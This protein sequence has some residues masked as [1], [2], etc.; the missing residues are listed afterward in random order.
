MRSIGCSTARL[1]AAIGLAALAVAAPAAWVG[2]QQPP[3]PTSGPDANPLDTSQGADGQDQAE[4][5]TSS[6][7]PR[8]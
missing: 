8:R 5:E 4:P 2:A 1:T 3:R 7:I 6:R